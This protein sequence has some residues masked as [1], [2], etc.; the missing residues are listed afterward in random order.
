M[1]D[2]EPLEGWEEKHQQLKEKE[3]KMRRNA[4]RR[5]RGRPAL[6]EE[7]L[8]FL[9]QT[10]LFLRDLA[11]GNRSPSSCYA[12]GLPCRGPGWVEC[13]Q[14]IGHSRASGPAELAVF[15]AAPASLGER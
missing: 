13:C 12:L 5:A 3:K 10:P 9:Q 8:Q 14:D 4:E 7:S 11:C 6:S 2:G 1:S 15:R